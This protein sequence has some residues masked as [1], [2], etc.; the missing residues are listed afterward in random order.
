MVEFE[1][2]GIYG[3]SPHECSGGAVCDALTGAV[4]CN[5]PKAILPFR[6]G[7]TRLFTLL[8][9]IFARG[10]ES[11]MKEVAPGV[12]LELAVRPGSPGGML[13][14]PGACAFSGVLR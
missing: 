11:A 9:R 2:W 8:S 14:G 3:D 10:V 6:L 7:E 13:F 5:G 4:V 1:W 12:S